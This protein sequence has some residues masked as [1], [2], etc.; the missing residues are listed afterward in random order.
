MYIGCVC[1]DGGRG[2]GGSGGGGLED[3]PTALDKFGPGYEPGL[4]RVSLC[5]A[6]HLVQLQSYRRALDQHDLYCWSK[7]LLLSLQNVAH[8][9][10]SSVTA[11]F[12]W[13]E[14]NMKD[15]LVAIHT[16][17]TGNPLTH[18]KFKKTLCHLY[19]MCQRDRI[20][21]SYSDTCIH[22]DH[23][24]YVWQYTRTYRLA[25][26]AFLRVNAIP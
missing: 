25:R 9:R 7:Y 19:T 2:V 12:T 23:A 3:P 22:S 26:P 14:F 24:I 4:C 10:Q 18:D 15:A 11:A 1:V 20:S 8:C 17:T 21:G 16:C 5:V 6:S 13:R